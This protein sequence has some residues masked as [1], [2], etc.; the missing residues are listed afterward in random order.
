M[1]VKMQ[2]RRA[3][4]GEAVGKR[5]GELERDEAQVK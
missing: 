2:R 5:S 3:E 4:V 1:V